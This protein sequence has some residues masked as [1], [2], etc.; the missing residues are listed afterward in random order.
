MEPIPVPEAPDTEESVTFE[1]L[2]A[3]YFE[4]EPHTVVHVEFG[5]LSHPGLVRDV[6][7]DHYLVV[8]RRRLRD[9]LLTNLPVELLDQ[10]EQAAYTLAVAD[11]MGGRAFGELASFL[12]LCTAWDLGGEE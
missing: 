2:V 10:A 8:R 1:E 4:V 9:V 11:G 6:N 7:E 12:A 5:A 3:R